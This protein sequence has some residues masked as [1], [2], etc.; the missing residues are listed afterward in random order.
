MII[1][2]FNIQTK[3]LFIMEHR[4]RCFSVSVKVLEAF[5]FVRVTATPEPNL[6]HGH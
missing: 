5:E 2:K 1:F 4:K 3:P 6:K